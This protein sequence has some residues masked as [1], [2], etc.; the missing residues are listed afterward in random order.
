MIEW[1]TEWMDEFD[2]DYYRVDTVKHVD[3]T[4]WSAL[5]NSLTKVNPDFKMIESTLEPDMLIPPENLEQEAWMHSLTSI[6]MI[7]QRIL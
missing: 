5:K 7:L 6:S 4:T 2:I 3:S 1:Q